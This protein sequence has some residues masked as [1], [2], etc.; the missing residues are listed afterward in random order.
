MS[1]LHGGGRLLH[2]SLPLVVVNPVDPGRWMGC[3]LM[4]SSSP[5]SLF[6]FDNA[7]VGQFCDYDVLKLRNMVSPPVPHEFLL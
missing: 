7:G 5:F 1:V 4:P 6:P 2:T 3:V